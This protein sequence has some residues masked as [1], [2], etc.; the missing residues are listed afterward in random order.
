MLIG[1]FFSYLKFILL[2]QSTVQTTKEM[3]LSV[4]CSREC[5]GC[6]FKEPGLNEESSQLFSCHVALLMP[7]PQPIPSSAASGLFSY[8]LAS[9]KCKIDFKW[10][11]QIWSANCSLNYFLGYF[12]HDSDYTG[13]TSLQKTPFDSLF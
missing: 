8:V 6:L 12:H 7:P 1:H 10:D 3:Q 2:V 4:Y 11:N 9:F 13:V 5:P